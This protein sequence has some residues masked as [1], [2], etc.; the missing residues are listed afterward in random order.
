M[1]NIVLFASGSGSNVEN[2]VQYFQENSEVNISAVLTNKTQAQVL[3][4]CNRLNINGLYFN[5]NA[6][7]ETDC[8]LDIVKTF[9]PDLIVLAGFLWKVPKN[10]IA[11]FPNKIVNIHP[12]L[13]PKYGGKGMYGNNV[14]EA[15]RANNETETGITIHYVNEN[16][17]EGAVIR[18]VKTSVLATD[19]PETIAHKVHELEYEYFPKVIEE[20]LR[21]E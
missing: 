4:R 10:L 21:G 11:N 7:Y 6:F 16:Y 8:V 14:H 1:K 12:A 17:D 3:D 18:Q 19:T 2:I 5:R 20:L 15:V 9:N 13:L